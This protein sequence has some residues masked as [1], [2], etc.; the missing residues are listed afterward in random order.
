RRIRPQLYHVAPSDL[1]PRLISLR[2]I[3]LRWL[4]RLRLY[5]AEAAVMLAFSCSSAARRVVRS[6]LVAQQ[7]SA[8]RIVAFTA[9]LIY[10]QVSATRTLDF[11][12]SQRLRRPPCGKALPFRGDPLLLFLAAT[13]PLSATR[14]TQSKTRLRFGRG[15]QRRRGWPDACYLHHRI[16]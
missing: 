9:A 3:S 15:A 12:H 10:R 6:D 2:L 1:F 5:I 11:G 7:V 4:I 16:N 8:T 13:P 14:T